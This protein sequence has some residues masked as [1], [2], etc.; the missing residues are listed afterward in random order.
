MQSLFPPKIIDGQYEVLEMLGR[1]FSGDVLKVRKDQQ[2]MA[3]KMLKTH[4]M[5]I[6]QAD[7]ISTFKFEFNLLKDLTHPNI[8]KIY[9]FGFDKELRR[10][11]FTVEWLDAVDLAQHAE[12]R[13]FKELEPL[14]LQ[15]L[16]G[17]SY[18]HAQNILHGD[19]KPQNLLVIQQDGKPILKIIDFGISH[20]Q[21][22][23]KG[24]TPATL[25][26]EK[27][28][29][30]PVD[31]RSDLYAIGVI[32]YTILT[33]KNP[34]LR[35]NV[36]KT[37]T[38]HLSF[39]PPPLTSV[40]P[41]VP[42]LWSKII[43]RL[44]QKNPNNRFMSAA[45]I[46][47]LLDREG[48][49]PTA[50]KKEYGLPAH[51]IGRPASLQILAKFLDEIKQSPPQPLVLEILGPS[52]VGKQRLLKELTYQAELSGTTLAPKAPAGQQAGQLWIM[53]ETSLDNAHEEI[54]LLLNK[55]IH[56]AG[57]NLQAS[58]Q[59]KQTSCQVLSHPLSCLTQ[60]EIEEYLKEVTHHSKIPTSLLDAVF[61]HSAGNVSMLMNILRSLMQDP[62]L[63]E[64]SGRWNLSTFE[65]APPSIEQLGLSSQPIPSSFSDLEHKDRSQTWHLA[66]LRAEN[67]IKEGKDAEAE[68]LT[69]MLE[70]NMPFASPSIERLSAKA[71]VLFVRGWLACR[72]KHLKEARQFLSG[73]ISLLEEA[74]L[75][76]EVLGLRTQNF[77]AYVEMEE[78]RFEHA[79]DILKATKRL[80]KILPSAKQFQVTNNDLGNAYK[81]NK[82]PELAISCL[83][84][85]IEFYNQL[86]DPSLAIKAY[87]NLGESYLMLGQLEPARQHYLLCANRA[88]ENRFWEYLL[89]AYNGLGNVDNFLKNTPEALEFYS[90]AETL[91]EY[92]KDYLSA[93]TTAQNRGVI[94]AENGRYDEALEDISRSLTYLKK[95]REPGP[96]ELYLKVRAHLEIG[97]VFRLKKDFAKAY[98][99][100]MESLNGSHEHPFCKSLTFYILESLGKLALDRG[101]PHSFVQIYPDLMEAA[102][103]EELRIRAQLLMQRSPIDPTTA[104]E[105]PMQENIISNQQVNALQAILSINRQ[106]LLEENL[107]IL[108]HR[109]LEFAIELS[110]AESA[111]IATLEKDQSLEVLTALNL[112]VTDA[113]KS[114]SQTIANKVLTTGHAITTH[115]ATADQEYNVHESV[116]ALHLR[117]ILCV[118]IRAKG[119]AM[120]ILYLS[121]SHQKALFSQEIVSTMEAFADQVALA[122]TNAQKITELKTLKG[123]LEQALGEAQIEIADLKQNL[124]D[125]ILHK[126]PKII[127]N[128]P[129]MLALL[130]MVDRLSETN[131]PVLIQGETG[132]GKE[133]IAHSLH[134]ASPRKPKAFVAVNCGAIPEN[135]LESELFGYKAGAFTGA[136]RDKKGLLEEAHGGT[137]F[138]DEIAELPLNMQVK[139]L[140]VLQEGEF[141]RL[142]DTKSTPV[143]L[144]IVAATHQNL[145]AWIKEKK[146]REDLYYRLSGI[147]LEM[148]PLRERK[149]DL[150]LLVD[151]FLQ[152]ASDEQ[153]KPKPIKMGKDLLAAL[154]S[155]DWPGN[156]RELENFIRTAIS[157]E[158]RGVIH[159]GTL[160][161]FLRQKIKDIITQPEQLKTESAHSVQT[162]LPWIENWKWNEYERAIYA[163]MLERHSYDIPKVAS[164]LN[165]GVATVYLKIKKYRLKKGEPIEAMANY[166]SDLPLENFKTWL[167]KKAFETTGHKPYKTAQKLGL[168][169]GTVY[170]YVK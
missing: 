37:L 165:V 16:S 28:L 6:N 126:H 120:G 152:K 89:L 153:K 53:L 76:H 128:S 137:L 110:G 145:N 151:H 109:I 83:L 27:I 11:Y 162:E 21:F 20:P 149:E 105:T 74:Q 24:G 87:Y 144:H 36:P 99:K 106:L 159:M 43:E 90:R 17:L 50:T 60:H 73:A 147:V 3:L 100:L 15:A 35:D 102:T 78:G 49:V 131:L 33:K 10:F 66:I 139:L 132:T 65:E 161:P 31:S 71:H 81:I 124:R 58:T 23:Q 69:N 129:K 79:I 123:Q 45:E 82:Q 107:E 14:F 103:S 52:G 101:D 113:I 26:P 40:A 77:L 51:W 98:A 146:F 2:L 114:M 84:E 160:P 133:L 42:P 97:D 134:D 150:P 118:P 136:N 12:N 59:L 92:L 47:R 95:I 167:L 48:L 39:V 148:P 44:L 19:L 117:S 91:A 93:A 34:F 62:L 138:L 25:S 1:G 166:P 88:R 32:F 96:H 57:F 143:D 38:S 154:L 155:Y 115:D 122:I 116:M 75:I 29:K 127:G 13:S 55:G 169:P 104:K 112:S 170:R 86:A 119:K 135:L 56:V 121:H 130:T 111:L 4:A 72:I 61:Q 157:F 46:L 9:D 22:V 63:C 168:N 30:E 94:L 70:E 68:S 164:L 141:T 7:L 54:S 64:P 67:L 8:V 85:E 163:Q 140:R 41:S 108:A 142:G 156:I 158:E 125:G 5:G 80:S 18:L